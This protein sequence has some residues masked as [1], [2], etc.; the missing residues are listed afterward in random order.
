M[1]RTRWAA[2]ARRA[3]GVALVTAA[4]VVVLARR[5][6]IAALTSGARPAPLAVALGLGL[7]S[8][9]Q[10]ALFWVRGLAA[11]GARRRAGEV[12]EATVAAI[13]AR[14]VPGSVWYAAG[15]VGHL[16]RGGTSAAALSTVA[17]VETVLSFVVALGFGAGLL[18]AS[19]EGADAGGP[20]IAGAAVALALIASPWVVN[21]VLRRLAR[22]RGTTAVPT[23]GW[24]GYLELCGH[25]VAFWATSAAAFLSYLAAFPEV[26]APG[27]VRTA[28]S[29]L[30]AWA[31]GF[32]AVFAPQGAGV[33]EAT[34]ASLLSGAPLA[35]LAVVVGG[36]RALTAVRDGLAL[37]GLAAWRAVGA[38]H[39]PSS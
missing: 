34:V 28:G 25:L 39:A 37:V 7:V 2:M 24:G 8:L 22:G 4:L 35:D 13:P 9:G 19:G 26:D 20:A 1:S 27:L 3:Y 32:A 38:R 12:L 23:L 29:F 6:Q 16:R 31:V 5:D 10:S 15:R 18:L 17:G 36:Y 33:F 30:V 14:Y 21:P 11:M